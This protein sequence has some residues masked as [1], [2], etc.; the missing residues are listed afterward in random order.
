MILFASVIL[1]LFVGLIRRGNIFRLN[2]LRWLLLAILPLLSVFLMKYYPT[3]PLLPKAAVTTFSYLCVIIFVVANRKFK[4]P[5]VLLG[6]GTLC[7]YL[8]IASNSFRMPIS[9]T[10]LSI[11]STMTPEA[12]IAQRADYFVAT[13]GANFL[14]LG[15]VIY[16]PL[17]VLGGF[18]SVGDILLAAGMF[19]LIV[20]VMGKNC[21]PSKKTT[22]KS[23]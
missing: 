21:L 7:N 20:Q 18:M 8:V 15:D 4:I 16:M 13:D 1:G 2:S 22:E 5:A 9:P 11:Y 17:K 23:N 3:I 14:F 12:V 19:L 10:A 6:L